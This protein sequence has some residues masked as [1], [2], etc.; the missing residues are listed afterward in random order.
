MWSWNL[1]KCIHFSVIF[2]CRSFMVSSPLIE[3]LIL[4]CWQCSWCVGNADL[5]VVWWWREKDVRQQCSRRLVGCI[6]KCAP[7]CTWSSNVSFKFIQFL[8]LDICK[9]LL[10]RWHCQVLHYNPVILIA[11]ALWSILQIGQHENVLQ[12]AHKIFKSL[13]HWILFYFYFSCYDS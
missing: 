7:Q 6:V 5:H 10:V 3:G 9:S 2:A 11:M 8:S 13:H 12:F 4:W 1:Y